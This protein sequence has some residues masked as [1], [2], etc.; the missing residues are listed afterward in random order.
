MTETIKNLKEQ[1]ALIQTKLSKAKSEL[2]QD[3]VSEIIK[4]CNENDI[5]IKDIT[6]LL[7]NKIPKKGIKV[8]PKYIDPITHTTWSGR[9]KT[10]KWLQKYPVEEWHNFLITTT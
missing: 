10:P 4:L 7:L 3:I 5:A 9:G 2:K 8:P 1:Q 6:N